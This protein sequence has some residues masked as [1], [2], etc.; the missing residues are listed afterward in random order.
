MFHY[1]HTEHMNKHFSVHYVASF[2]PR[3]RNAFLIKP[4][5]FLLC[6]SVT[7]NPVI[8]FTFTECLVIPGLFGTQQVSHNNV[9]LLLS[10][11]LDS[12]IH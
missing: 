10:S 9:F 5:I 8:H 1:L 7:C 3:L 6:A 2:S 11:I 12:A 4:I